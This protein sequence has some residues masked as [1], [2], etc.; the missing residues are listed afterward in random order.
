MEP[1]VPVSDARRAER[2]GAARAK[3]GRL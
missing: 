1:A 2:G 3:P